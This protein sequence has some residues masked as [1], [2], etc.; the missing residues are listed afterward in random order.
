MH[1]LFFWKWEHYADEIKQADF[2]LRQGW[3][4]RKG[5]QQGESIW[6]FTRFKARIYS[7]VL[8]LV[9]LEDRDLIG[10]DAK[11]HGPYAVIGDKHASRYFDPDNQP[12]FEELVRSLSIEPKAGILG[13][14]FQ[15][16]NSVK[17]LSKQDHE[18]LK[19]YAADLP[20]LSVVTCSRSRSTTYQTG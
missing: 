18:R 5:V 19:T 17:D 10:E 14:S 20:L 3:E 6:A 15:G 13:H 11:W 9:K 16:R 8:D 7:L 12:G 1:K 2:G 4:W